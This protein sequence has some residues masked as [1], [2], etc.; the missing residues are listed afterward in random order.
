[1]WD[2]NPC[3]EVRRLLWEIARLQE[4]A[5]QVYDLLES[6]QGKSIDY[7]TS[8]RLANMRNALA[9]EPAVKRAMAIRKR[10]AARRAAEPRP[11]LGTEMFPQFVGPPWPWPPA[12]TQ[13]H[14]SRR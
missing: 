12:R 10:E 9:T 13:R 4:Q 7:T 8:L 2:A 6:L 3:P 5:T 1:M 11:V 14:R